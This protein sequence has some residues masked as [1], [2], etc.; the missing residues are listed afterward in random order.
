MS[1][2]YFDLKEKLVSPDKKYIGYLSGISELVDGIEC[3]EKGHAQ[4]VAKLADEIAAELGLSESS[5]T[6]LY[7]ASLLHDVGEMVLPRNILKSSTKLDKE[8][9]YLI[10]NH[11]LIGE[12]Q[13]RGKIELLDEVPSIVRWH[14]ERYDGF[15]YPDGLK[16]DEIPTTAQILNLAD[17]VV[18]MQSDRPY[19][20]AF[21]FERIKTEVLR[22]S[23]LQFSPETVKAWLELVDGPIDKNK[24]EN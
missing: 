8:Q 2:K 7:I 15:G 4:N 17:A 6:S 16:G 1:Y 13:L 21:K 12:M 23:G 9:K 19:R 20:N 3:H 5:R 18:S 11:P 10:Q 24:G 22:Q 14:H